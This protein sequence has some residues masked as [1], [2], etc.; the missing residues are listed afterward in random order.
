M[1]GY[2]PALLFSDGR[3]NFF[4][5]F[6][7]WGPGAISIVIALLVAVLTSNSRIPL[8][9]VM[10]IGLGFEVAGSFGIAAAEFLDPTALDFSAQW[11]GLSWVAVW[12][13]LFTVVVP[14]SPRRTVIASLASVSSVPI[15]TGFV[16]ANNTVPGVTLDKFFLGLI[17]PYLLVVVMAYVGARVIYALGKEVT[18]ARELGGYRL[19]E[20]LGAGG[21]GEVWRAEH[22]LLARPAAIKLVRPEFVGRSD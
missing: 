5:R 12:T 13:L 3:A 20:H 8:A 18:R 2:F 17:F 4:S 9:V 6:A 15:V 7:L 16:I 22:H 11:V 10:A 21:M 14:S 19:V 1:A